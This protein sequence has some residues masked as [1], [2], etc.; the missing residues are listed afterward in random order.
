MINPQ[1]LKSP[2]VNPV[3]WPWASWI[4]AIFLAYSVPLLSCLKLLG[5]V[6]CSAPRWPA[7]AGD[8]CPAMCFVEEGPETS[9]SVPAV[10]GG[11]P[12]EGDPESFPLGRTNQELSR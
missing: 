11:S 10:M 7:V 4:D 8:S 1:A 3:S 6:V 9:P 5:R 2:G 12:A